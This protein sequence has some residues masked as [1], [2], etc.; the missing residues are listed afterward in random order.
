MGLPPPS[1]RFVA[2]SLAWDHRSWCFVL[3]AF[4]LLA[5]GGWLS[6]HKHRYRITGSATLGEDGSAR[7]HRAVRRL[8]SGAGLW[9]VAGWSA[10][11]FE[12]LLVVLLGGPEVGGGTISLMI[13]SMQRLERSCRS[14]EAWVAFYGSCRN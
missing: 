4:A 6:V 11:F 5:L 14:F 8:T 2:F 13:V 12:V 1:R 10:A 7:G 9:S 3:A